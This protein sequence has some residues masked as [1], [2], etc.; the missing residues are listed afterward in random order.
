MR[1]AGRGCECGNGELHRYIDRD[2]Y[3][4]RKNWKPSKDDIY[5]I[6]STVSEL[7]GQYRYNSKKP[8]NK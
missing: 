8:G 5:T 3:A 7:N 1:E 2:V 6:H 4:R